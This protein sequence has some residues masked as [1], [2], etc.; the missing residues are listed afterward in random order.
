MGDVRYTWNVAYHRV[1]GLVSIGRYRSPSKAKRSAQIAL[2][3]AKVNGLWPAQYRQKTVSGYSTDDVI[4]KLP[5]ALC[6]PD[7]IIQAMDCDTRQE[8][9][10]LTDESTGR[11]IAD[12]P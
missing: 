1:F 7:S 2:T 8:L 9:D 6:P 12:G 11:V 3:W 4:G 10:P 5:A